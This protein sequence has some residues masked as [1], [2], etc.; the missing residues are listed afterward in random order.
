LP[1]KKEKKKA[2]FKTSS[3]SHFKFKQWDRI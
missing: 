3:V 1:P 2:M